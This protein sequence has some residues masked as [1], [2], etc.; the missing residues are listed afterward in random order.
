MLGYR[1]LWK[2]LSSSYPKFYPELI[3]MTRVLA[4]LLELIVEERE[5][6]LELLP[7]AVLLSI[8]RDKDLTA[9]MGLSLKP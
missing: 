9:S 4:L 8:L 5:M 6:R 1:P 7:L 2:A 3:L